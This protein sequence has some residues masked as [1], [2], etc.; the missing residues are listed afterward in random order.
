MSNSLEHLKDSLRRLAKRC[1]DIKYTEAL[2]LAFLMTGLLVF[3]E[4][5]VNSPE[6]KEMR[7]SID[8]SISDMKKLFKEAKAENNRLLKGANLELIQLMEQGDHVVKSPWSS[9]QFG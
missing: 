1:K 5:G 8:T 9:W 2:L 3:S 6:I 4:A 7:Q